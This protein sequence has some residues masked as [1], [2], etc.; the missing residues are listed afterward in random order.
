MKS[1]PFRSCVLRLVP[2]PHNKTCVAGPWSWFSPQVEEFL[3]LK[4][5]LALLSSGHGLAGM[6]VLGGWLDSMILEVFS[7]LHDSVILIPPGSL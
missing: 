7:N 3:S 2:S 4:M 1:F 6:G 5:K